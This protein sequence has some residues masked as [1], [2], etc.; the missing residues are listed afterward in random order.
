MCQLEEL[1]EAPDYLLHLCNSPLYLPFYSLCIISGVNQKK[2]SGF[3][4]PTGASQRC[5]Y[6]VLDHKCLRQREY[7]QYFTQF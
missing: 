4:G 2:D 5:E 1:N 6:A 3:E 7:M